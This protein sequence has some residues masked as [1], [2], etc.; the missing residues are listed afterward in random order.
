MTSPSTHSFTP[1]HCW[2]LIRYGK[3]IS[4]PLIFP[5]RPLYSIILNIDTAA[6][7]LLKGSLCTQKDWQKKSSSTWTHHAPRLTAYSCLNMS[8]SECT[9]RSTS[10][11]PMLEFGWAQSTLTKPCMNSSLQRWD[12]ALDVYNPIHSI[13]SWPSHNLGRSLLQSE[14]TIR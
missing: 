6:A 5:L 9:S 8:P 7:L 13:I 3:L 10:P 4:F 2:L 12:L 14:I 1:T 11:S